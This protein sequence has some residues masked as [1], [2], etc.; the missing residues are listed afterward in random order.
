MKIVAFVGKTGGDFKNI[1][2][3]CFH[4][5][6]NV[7][8]LIQEA[9]MLL[10]HCIC[11]NLDKNLKENELNKNVIKFS[12]D[13]YIISEIGINHN[14]YLFLAKK[15]IKSSV[16]A[17]ANAV[18]FQ[19]RDINDLVNDQLTLKEAKSY[20]SKHPYDINHKSPKF[21]AWTYLD[22]NSTHNIKNKMI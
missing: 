5:Q 13:P 19:K 2:D 10:L 15:L 7:I 16:L 1:S 3:I 11:E 8:S 12:K 14:D 4:I 17:G 6:N 9:H 21:G 22:T 20:L 18:K